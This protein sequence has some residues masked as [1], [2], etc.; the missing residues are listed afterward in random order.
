MKAMI[1][2]TG[3]IHLIVAVNR[4]FPLTAPFSWVDVD[5]NT[6]VGWFYSG[7]QPIPP[8]SSVEDPDV[9]FSEQ[10]LRA[11]ADLASAGD[12]D[13]VVRRTPPARARN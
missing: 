7:G 1:D 2:A 6:Q 8:A 3:R 10:V 12:I 13:Q 5:A 4:T 11:M 9:P